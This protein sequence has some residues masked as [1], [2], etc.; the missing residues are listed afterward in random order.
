[1]ALWFLSTC[2]LAVLVTLL[3][4]YQSENMWLW[5]I[6]LSLY[7]VGWAHSEFDQLRDVFTKYGPSRGGAKYFADP[8]NFLD[9]AIVAGLGVLL[10][11]RTLTTPTDTLTTP[12]NTLTTTAD[13]GDGPELVGPGLVGLLGAV[14]IPSQALVA[15]FCWL[16]I[17]QVCIY[18]MHTHVSA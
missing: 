6:L 16:R 11:S 13:L 7:M 12:T 15:L 9:I 3:P 5:L 18:S 10:L 14:A 17:M 4:P 2:S 1:M 8:F